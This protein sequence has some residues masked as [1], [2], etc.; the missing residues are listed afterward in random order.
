KVGERS[1]MLFFTFHDIQGLVEA[2]GGSSG[3]DILTL[4][5]QTLSL[6]L[7]IDNY[8]E[9]EKIVPILSSDDFQ[10]FGPRFNQGISEEEYL[11]MLS[12]MLGDEAPDAVR[13]S[14]FTIKIDTPKPIAS[15]SNMQK[16]STYTASFTFPLIDVLLLQHPID[17]SVSWN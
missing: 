8:P 15:V 2:L 16:E 3:Q 13:T 9:L 4:K 11:D 1:Y 14:S 7:S 17:A 5:D 6:H 10:P 12:F